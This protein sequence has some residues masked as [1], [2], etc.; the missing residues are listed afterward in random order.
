VAV[1]PLYPVHEMED[2]PTGADIIRPHG[3]RARK[4]KHTDVCLTR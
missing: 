4:T 3:T 2:E 1:A